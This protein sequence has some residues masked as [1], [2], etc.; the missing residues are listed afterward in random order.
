MTARR[1]VSI[2]EGMNLS[3]AI[4][5]LADHGWGHHGFPWGLL[6]GLFWLAVIA[7]VVWL[8]IRNGRPRAR[9]GLEAARDIL[10]ERF[11]RGEITVDEYRRRLEQLG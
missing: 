4:T 1:P 6:F 2:I 5:I 8:V 3:T 11:A 9:S 7:G 10:A